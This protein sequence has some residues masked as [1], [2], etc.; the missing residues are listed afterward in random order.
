[1]PDLT[2]LSV[3]G[4]KAGWVGAASLP[5]GAAA[6]FSTALVAWLSWLHG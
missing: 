2:G 5:P 1:M 3:Q 4:V 6:A